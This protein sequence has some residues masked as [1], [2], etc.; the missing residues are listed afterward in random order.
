MSA[1]IERNLFFLKQLCKK[2]PKDRKIL[3][4]SCDN[5]LINSICEVA[6]NTLLGNVKVKKNHLKVLKKHANHL[7]KLRDRK[8]SVKRKRA[9]LVQNGGFLPALLAPIISLAAT[10]LSNAL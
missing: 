8:V 4:R 7:K 10:L 6:D 3:L 9:V 1:R 5:D 2:P